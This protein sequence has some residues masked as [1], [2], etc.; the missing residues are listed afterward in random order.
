MSDAFGAFLGASNPTTPAA[1]NGDFQRVRLHYAG[2][3]NRFLADQVQT[4]PIGLGPVQT[5]NEAVGAGEARAAANLDA[6]HMQFE[7]GNKSPEAKSA[8]TQ[9]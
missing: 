1:K 5:E 7:F 9:K 8:S 3:V 4:P 6:F 2:N